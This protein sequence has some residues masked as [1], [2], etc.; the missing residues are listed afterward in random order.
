MS[1][2]IR[3][4]KTVML[5]LQIL[6]FRFD[7]LGLLQCISVLVSGFRLSALILLFVEFLNIQIKY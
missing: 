1:S 6:V 2:V 5:K 7:S 3:H 4:G